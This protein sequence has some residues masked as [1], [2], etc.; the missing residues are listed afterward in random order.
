LSDDCF[1]LRTLRHYRNRVLTVMP[2]GRAAIAA[3]YLVAP[4][5][6][7]RVPCNERARRL[8]SVYAIAA[9]FGFKHLAY[10]RYARMMHVLACEYELEELRE[11]RH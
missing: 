2:D 7:Q 5:I 8:L 9:R 4:S 10:R 1:E 3:Y 6:L 11:S